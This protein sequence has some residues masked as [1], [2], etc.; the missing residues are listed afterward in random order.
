MS[1]EITNEELQ[2][3]IARIKLG[4][5]PGMDGVTPEII[6]FMEESAEKVLKDLV[7]DITRE[8]KILEEWRKD[9]ILPLRCLKKEIRETVQTIT[10]TS[11][12]V[13][14]NTCHNNTRKDKR[15]IEQRFGRHPVW[16]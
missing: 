14:V 9:I 7:N 6:R 13:K 2:E 4:K 15:K 1:A 5:A 12:P 8:K 10:L 16:I 3:A 11:I